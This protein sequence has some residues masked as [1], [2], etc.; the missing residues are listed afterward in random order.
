MIWEKSQK[1]AVNAVQTSEKES[2]AG[3]AKG[4]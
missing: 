1:S 4:I 2:C 3:N